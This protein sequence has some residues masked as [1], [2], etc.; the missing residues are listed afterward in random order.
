MI[1]F[2]FMQDETE[3]GGRTYLVT[4]C[5]KTVEELLDCW[6]ESFM[7]YGLIDANEDPIDE[8]LMKN[9]LLGEFN[10]HMFE[11]EDGVYYTFSVVDTD[12]DWYYP[13]K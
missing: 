3:V 5:F 10:D 2:T 12:S 1:V 6:L 11:T 9:I 13:N 4:N 7:T 8:D